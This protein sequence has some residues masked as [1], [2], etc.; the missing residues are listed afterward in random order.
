MAHAGVDEK[1]DPA[2]AVQGDILG[3]MPRDRR[4]AQPLEQ[5][6]QQLR[7]RRGVFDE[8]ETVR[9]HGVIVRVA[10]GFTW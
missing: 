10:H 1:I 9:P 7:I 3:A 2:L 5:R 6:A 8:L 4:E